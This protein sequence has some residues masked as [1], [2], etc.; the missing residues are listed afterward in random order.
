MTVDGLNLVDGKV[1]TLL[2]YKYIYGSA[3]IPPDTAGFDDVYVLSILA[4]QWRETSRRLILKFTQIPQTHR[5]KPYPD[6]NNETGQYPHH[7]LTCN[8]IDDGQT[9]IM[10]GAFPLTKEC[11]VPNQFGSHNLDMGLQN[12]DLSPWK[13]LPLKPDI[14]CCS[15]PPSQRHWRQRARQRDQ[16]VTH[17]RLLPSG[18]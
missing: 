17:R 15:R 8:V 4:F 7:S 10:G 14:I 1:L 11:D 2:F 16:S 12:T 5:V 6:R 9:M 13:T 18:S 3:G